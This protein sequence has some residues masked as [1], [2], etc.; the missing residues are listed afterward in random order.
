MATSYYVYT[1]ILIGYSI[2]MKLVC[3]TCTWY[4][5][6]WGLCNSSSLIIGF[7]LKQLTNSSYSVAVMA[8]L[9]FGAYF[10]YV[11][12][13]LRRQRFR[14]LRVFCA[15]S[16]GSAAAAAADV[17]EGGGSDAGTDEYIP[18][19]A[20]ANHGSTTTAVD[21]DF[22][23]PHTAPNQHQQQLAAATIHNARDGYF[24]V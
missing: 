8:V 17:E 22:P 1:W 6:C 4:M 20:D 7:A 19:N 18:A 14:N 24:D 15:S 10:E 13:R 2:G 9:C 3:P 21:A 11:Y 5:Y 12:N 16:S 23:A